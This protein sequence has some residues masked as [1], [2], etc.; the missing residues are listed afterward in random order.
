MNTLL[1]EICAGCLLSVCF[2]R[3][4]INFFTSA[5]RLLLFFLNSALMTFCPRAE[6]TTV[7]FWNAS[8]QFVS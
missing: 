3:L 2:A 1:A 4:Y 5:W 8:A 7:L 6:R